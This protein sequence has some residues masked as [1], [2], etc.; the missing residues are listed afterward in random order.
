MKLNTDNTH[1]L[2]SGTENEH[3]QTKIDDDKILKSNE[4]K[5]SGVRSDNK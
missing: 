1:S 2:V 4:V 5:V 3:S